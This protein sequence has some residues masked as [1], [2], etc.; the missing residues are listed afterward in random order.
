LDN[1]H[2]GIVNLFGSV[3]NNKDVLNFKDISTLTMLHTKALDL[4]HRG[5]KRGIGFRA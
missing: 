3:V 1:L 4:G 5:R 2:A